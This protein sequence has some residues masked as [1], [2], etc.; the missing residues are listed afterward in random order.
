MVEI[1]HLEAANN[2][3][4]F[5][6]DPFGEIAAQELPDIDPNGIAIRQRRP[7]RAPADRGP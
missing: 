4:L 6:D 1:D 2:V 5:L 3:P 7:F